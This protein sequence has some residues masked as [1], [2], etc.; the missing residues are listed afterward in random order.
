MPRSGKRHLLVIYP[1]MINRWWKKVLVIGIFLLVIA[2]GLAELPVLYPDMGFLWVEDW[3]LWIIAGAGLIAILFSIFLV[4]IR[5]KAYVQ[6]FPDHLRVVTPFLRLNISYRRIQSTHTA[7]MQQLFPS[8]KLPRLLRE[9]IRPLAKNNCVMI[10]MARF[11]ISRGVARF[12][13]SP[14]FFPDKTAKLCLLVQDWIA[15]STDLDSYFTGWQDNQRPV[16]DHPFS[17]RSGNSQPRR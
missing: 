13:L 6:P 17:N 11:P 7:E 3:R 15:F 1:L 8:N 4:A 12:F 14:L 5:K 9:A 16:P 10:N 2:A